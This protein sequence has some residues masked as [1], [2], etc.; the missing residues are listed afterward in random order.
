MLAELVQKPKVT[1][2]NHVIDMHDTPSEYVV[3]SGDSLW[4]IARRFQVTVSELCE[5]NNLTNQSVLKIGAVL[6]IF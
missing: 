5:L 3:K 1:P 6:R 2:K 4:L